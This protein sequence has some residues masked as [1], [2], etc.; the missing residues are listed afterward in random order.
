MKAFKRSAS[1]I[2]CL[3]MCLSILAGCG[4]RGD[5]DASASQPEGADTET[6]AEPTYR[7]DLTVILD[8]NK[9]ASIDIH[10]PAANLLPVRWVCNLMFNTLVKLEDGEYKP[11]LATSWETDDWQNFTFRLRDDVV[12]H[13]GEKFTADDVVF[14]FERAQEIATGTQAFDNL[15][16]IETMT[17]VDDHTVQFTTANIDVEFL[18]KLSNVYTSIMNR[19][20]VEEDAENG[21]YVGT[22]LWM[23]S[24]FAA[25]DYAKFAVNTN[26]WGESTPT[27]TLTLKYVAELP[28][29][30]IQLENDEAQACFQLDASDYAYVMSDDRFATDTITVNSVQYIAF[31]MNDPLLRDVNFRKAVASALNRQDMINAAQG[32]YGV[33]PP[34]GSFWGVTTMYR[35]TDIPL[36]PNDLDAAKEFLAASS[37]KGESVEIVA[38]NADIVLHTQII[39]AELK[40]IGINAEI[41]QTDANGLTAYSKYED[42]KAQMTSYVGPFNS[43]ASSVRSF[44]Y[45]GSAANRASY[46]NSGV[47]ELLDKVTVTGDENEREQIY[48]DIQSIVAE[49]LPYIALYHRINVFTSLAGV[50]GIKLSPD[51]THDIAYICMVN[52]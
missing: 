1:A 37:Y 28:A 30:L 25:N 47:T 39:Q 36:L 20:A 42:N 7:E 22:G 40:A 44:L 2:L 45:P 5:S 23:L 46:N 18:F 4:D 9:L 52:N 21:I 8:N 51:T 31:N 50:S 26:Y 3:V 33:A 41:F 38:A 19:K 13:N 35:N 43:S 14:T 27:K 32:G 6:A 24:D 48:K 17:A 12:F 34:D 29:R 16:D 15:K 11:S 49:D 10:N